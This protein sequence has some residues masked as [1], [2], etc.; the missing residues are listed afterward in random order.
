MAQTN[1][2]NYFKITRNLRLCRPAY[3]STI[4]HLHHPEIGSDKLLQNCKSHLKRLKSIDYVDHKSLRQILSCNA[5]KVKI[6]FEWSR[7]QNDGTSYI[8]EQKLG[9]NLFKP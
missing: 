7:S 9:V 5:Y 2:Y 1:Q 6:W 4:R 3:K 8:S